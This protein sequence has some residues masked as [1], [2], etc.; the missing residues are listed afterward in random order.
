M[1]AT[2][3]NKKIM[4]QNIKYYM[5][6]IG[7]NQKE[8]CKDL[9]FKE[10]TFSDWVNAKTFPRIDKI[11]AMAEYFHVE[12]S[13]LIENHSDGRGATLPV[14][15]Y[16]YVSESISAGMLENVDALMELPTMSVPDAILGQYARDK[17]IVFMKVNGES[18]NNVIENHTIMAVKTG[19]EK[20]QLHNSDIVVASNHGSY[21]VKRF[22]NDTAHQR[23]ILRPD[24]SDP[25]FSDIIISYEDAED[26]SIFGRVVIYSVVL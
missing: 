22:Y 11:E 21:T 12:K 26:F 13:A 19:I 4:A 6:L 2:K 3:E 14:F 23:I 25:S 9:G 24:S 17:S 7:K 15:D 5:N 16:P 18:M 8:I 20:G 10:M 1:P